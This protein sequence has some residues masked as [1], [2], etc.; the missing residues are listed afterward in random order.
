MKYPLKSETE[1]IAK[2]LVECWGQYGTS[3]FT[4]RAIQSGGVY[5]IEMLSS[6]HTH[7]HG[8]LQGMRM[9]EL[10]ELAQY[11]LI[12]IDGN[13]ITL[14][15]ELRNAVEG[16]FE[17]TPYH[18]AKKNLI[19]EQISDILGVEL[20]GA[21]KQLKQALEELKDA[22]GGDREPKLGKVVSE[23]GN[24]LQHGANTATVIQALTFLGIVL[25]HI[26]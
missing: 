10:R 19:S 12:Q 24:L 25:H 23:L 3:Q 1:E 9:S 4:Y 15:Q 14:L 5:Q 16:S 2:R 6:T 18:V 22:I 11:D 26:Y 7:A 17:L 21:N 20:L 8:E 13:E